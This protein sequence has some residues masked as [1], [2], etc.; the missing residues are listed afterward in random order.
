MI[1]QLGFNAT[2]SS[3]SAIWWRSVLVAEDAGVLG[4]NPRP[5]A[6]N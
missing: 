6:G 4:E 1:D 2:L 3:I 5:W